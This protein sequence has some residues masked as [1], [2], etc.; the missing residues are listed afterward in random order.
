LPEAFNALEQFLVE[1]D[2]EVV[3]Y[4]VIGIIEGLQNRRGDLYLPF[5]GPRSR[6]AWIELNKDWEQVGRNK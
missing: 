1:G 6:S 4:A 2:S 3:E 5:V